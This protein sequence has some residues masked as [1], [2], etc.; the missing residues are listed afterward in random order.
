MSKT[1]TCGIIAALLAS[2]SLIPEIQELPH[3]VLLAKILIAFSIAANSIGHCFA[4][5]DDGKKDK[6]NLTK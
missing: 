3:G 2:L 4:K 6:P 1:S 5:D